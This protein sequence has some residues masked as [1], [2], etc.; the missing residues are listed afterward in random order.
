MC[1]I[2]PPEQIV[3]KFDALV[4]LSGLSAVILFIGR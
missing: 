3:I 2:W 4:E 1:V